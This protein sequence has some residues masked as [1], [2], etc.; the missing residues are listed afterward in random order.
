MW[1]IVRSCFGWLV[2]KA[3]VFVLLLAILVGVAWVRAELGNAAGRKVEL[4]GLKKE[5]LA[6]VQDLRVLDSKK[7]Q[8]ETEIRS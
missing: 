7:A 2:H 3:L 5:H 1:A 6:A 4:D 8:I